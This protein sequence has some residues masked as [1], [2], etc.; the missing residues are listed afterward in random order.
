MPADHDAGEADL[1][2]AIRYSLFA[3]VSIIVNITTQ[4]LLIRIYSSEFAVVLSV[5]AGTATGLVS[6][7]LL[8]K[9]YIFYFRSKNLT[10]DMRLFTAYTATGIGTTLLFWACE[11]SFEFLFGSRLARYSGAVLGLTL[12]YLLKYRLDKKLVFVEAEPSAPNKEPSAPNK[13]PLA[14]YEEPSA[15]NQ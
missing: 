6:K 10:H 15:R 12:G 8:D 5:L 1:N 3:V 7:F 11:F 14:Q 13:E 2:I 9:H 4:D